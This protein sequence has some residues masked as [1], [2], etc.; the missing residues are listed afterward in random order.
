M[1]A[2]YDALA[3]A[4]Q[5]RGLS[6]ETLEVLA[7]GSRWIELERDE[8]LI[9]QGSYGNDA[10]V[11]AAGR[12]E[13][14][15]MEAS[16]P[17]PLAVVGPGELVGELSVLD[18]QRTRSATVIALIPTQLVQIDGATLRASMAG[19]PE[20]RAEFSA[21]ARRMDVGR[22]IKA[23]T[24][25]Q[26]LPPD[27]LMRIATNVHDRRFALGEVIV[28]QGDVGAEC[29]LIRSGECEVIDEG[30][31]TPRTLARLG[32]GAMF[33]EAAVLTNAPRNAT[34]RATLE[35]EVLVLDRNAI[36]T[37]MKSTEGVARRVLSMLDARSR[38]MQRPQI[39]LHERVT[40][41][42]TRIGI[43]KDREAGQYFW[44]SP[45]ALFIWKRLD[46]RRTLRDLTF[47]LLNEHRLLAPDIVLETVRRLATAGFARVATVSAEVNQALGRQKR[48]SRWFPRLEWRMEFQHMDGFFSVLYAI[49]R[50]LYTPFGAVL[51]GATTLIGFVAFLSVAPSIA[52]SLL[53]GSMYARAGIALLPLIALAIVAHELGHGLAAKSVGAVVSRMEC[54]W[55]VIRPY[56]SVDTSDAWLASAR[57]RMFVDAGGVIVNLVLA[58]IAGCIAAF[59]RHQS[60][61]MVL[62]WIFA[63]WSYLAV[64]RNLNPLVEYDGYDLLVDWLDKPNLR[65]KCLAWF[66]TEFDDAVHEPKKLAEHRLELWYGAGILAYIV[67]LTVWLSYAYHNTLQGLVE[68]FAPPSSANRASQIVAI[69]IASL[70]IL[71]LLV[72]LR[73]QRIADAVRPARRSSGRRT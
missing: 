61:T 39:E 53:L 17:I 12:L 25:F 22:I 66:A 19:S 34:V 15:T 36:L 3:R 6:R 26:E 31:K 45:E 30:A 58:G 1:S 18:P 23:A 48:R 20:L 63:L 73:Q 42:G 29:Y 41:D 72:D 35:T 68:K 47:D 7:G 64:L 71:Q 11:V 54:G 40:T 69:T 24:A 16:G 57:N 50:P 38:P 49:V 60:S 62:A 8:V 13:V 59:S 10:Y 43:L 46:G 52:G 14:I 4:W 2:L 33:G 37:A 5:L 32:P 65:Q 67:A 9:S 44:L 56:F 27:T 70:A 21:N 55:M 28:Q 51:A